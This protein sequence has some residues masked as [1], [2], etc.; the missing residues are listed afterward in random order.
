MVKVVA[1]VRQRQFGFGNKQR[2]VMTGGGPDA[3]AVRADKH[4][5]EATGSPRLF[6][7]GADFAVSFLSV[8]GFAHPA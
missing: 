6:N 7:K 3:K 8:L 1:G 2:V 4:R 5:H